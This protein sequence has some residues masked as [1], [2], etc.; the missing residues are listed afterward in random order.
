MVRNQYTPGVNCLES[1]FPEKGLGIPGTWKIEHGTAMRPH[2]LMAN[3]ANTLLG[4]IRQKAARS[5]L[6]CTGQAVHPVWGSPVQETRGFT[7]ASSKERL[8]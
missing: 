3:V 1:S 5:A 2:A 8:R 7:G 4:C 6:V